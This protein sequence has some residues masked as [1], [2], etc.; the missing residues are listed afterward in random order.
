MD[1][2][3]T[4]FDGVRLPENTKE[5]GFI[6][7]DKYWGRG[8]MTEALEAAKKFAFEELHL[9]ALAMCHAKANVGSGR[10]QEKNGFNIVGIRKDYR[11]WIDGT[12]TSLIQRVMTKDEYFSMKK[13]R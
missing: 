2:H 4:R 5:I 9:D 3:E 10:V 13:T 11:T 1:V 12:V 8:V 6:L 7:N